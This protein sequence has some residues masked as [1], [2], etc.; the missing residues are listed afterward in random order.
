MAKPSSGHFSGTAGKKTAY[1]N[2][3]RNIDRDAIILPRDLDLREHPT[4]YKQMSSKKLKV[5]REKEAN[6]TLTKEEYKEWQRRLAVRR[7]K[8]ITP[9]ALQSIRICRIAMS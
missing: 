8:A 1:K 7:N 5:L 9:I 2:Q 6:R 4:K 3:Y